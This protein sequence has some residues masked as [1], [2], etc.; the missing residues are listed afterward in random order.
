VAPAGWIPVWSPPA[1][2]R[3]VRAVI[4]V[5]GLFALTDKVIGNLQMAT[6]AAFGGF[7]T[8]V[9]AGFGGT[10]REKLL[11]HTAL[12]IAG[13]ALLTIGTLVSSSTALA[14]LATVPVTFAVFFAGVAGPNAAAGVTAAL[15]AYI[16]PAASLGAMSVVP[17]RLAGWWM[18]SVA[19]TAAVLLLSPRLDENALRAAAAKV[20]S[21]LADELRG[22][23]RG[24]GGA[25][26]GRHARGQAW[27]AGALHRDAVAP[28]RTGRVRPGAGQCGRVARM[29]HGAGRRRRSRASR[30]ARRLAGHP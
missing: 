17:D 26:P 5:C 13:S 30:P 29:V 2:L 6:F 8:L 3:A 23:G 14:A 9:L 1:A 25:P 10:R 27:T 4:V 22:A 21:A 11:A 16:L 28:D 20:A 18:A 12:A 19:G 24:C 15:L 7:A